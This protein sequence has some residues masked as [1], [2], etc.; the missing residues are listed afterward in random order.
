MEDLAVEL[1][2]RIDCCGAYGCLTS[3]AVSVSVLRCL[4][5]GCPVTGG[6]VSRGFNYMFSAS[7]ATHNCWLDGASKWWVQVSRA[8]ACWSGGNCVLRLII[9]RDLLLGYCIWWVDASRSSCRVRGRRLKCPWSELLA[10]TRRIVVA[11]VAFLI[12]KQNRNG[13][14]ERSLAVLANAQSNPRSDVLS[15]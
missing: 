9:R 7:I 6:H 8:E 10:V 13:T 15:Q 5:G 12:L 2:R 1:T 14:G 11:R 4:A 3:P